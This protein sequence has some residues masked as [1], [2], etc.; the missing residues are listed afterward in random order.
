LTLPQFRGGLSS[1]IGSNQSQDGEPGQ[2]AAQYP[3]GVLQLR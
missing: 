3:V 1:A 2:A